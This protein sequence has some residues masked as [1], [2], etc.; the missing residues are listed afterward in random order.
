MSISVQTTW[1]LHRLRIESTFLLGSRDCGSK[2]ADSLIL[3]THRQDSLCNCVD[4]LPAFR[5]LY[6]HTQPYAIQEISSQSRR[7]FF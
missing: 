5:Q 3:A 2:D 4:I 7:I 1:L 6:E